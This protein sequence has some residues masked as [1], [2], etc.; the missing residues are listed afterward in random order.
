VFA[1][2]E[3]VR[4]YSAY[5]RGAEELLATYV[6]LDL[7]PKGRNEAWPAHN[8]ADWVRHHDRHGEPGMVD[9]SGRFRPANGSDC[10]CEAA[11][12]R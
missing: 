11:T 6:C 10:G 4:S 5:G 8:L 9:G 7:T 12:R 1:E 3:L 2:R